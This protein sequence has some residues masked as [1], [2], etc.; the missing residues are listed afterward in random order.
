E[1]IQA[2]IDKN[3]KLFED[4]AKKLNVKFDIFQKGSNPNH[5]KSSQKLWELCDKNGDIYK[6]SYRG[7]YCVGCE[8]FY[9]KEELTEDG[10]CFEHPGKKLEE[11]E[12]E[13]Y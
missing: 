13:N 9:T 8:Q 1:N 12:E 6:K 4:L 11:V 7:L 5:H 10:Q 3:A 2:F